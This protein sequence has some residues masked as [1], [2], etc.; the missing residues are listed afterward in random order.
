MCRRWLF[1][2]KVANENDCRD[3]QQTQEAK[4]QIHY[5]LGFDE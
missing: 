1:R 2:I 5:A 3:E 4:K